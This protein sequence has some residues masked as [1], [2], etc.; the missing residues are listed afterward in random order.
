M[1]RRV[2]VR[3]DIHVPCE[4]CRELLVGDLPDEIGH[5]EREH[6][7]VLISKDTKTISV[8][9]KEPIHRTIAILGHPAPK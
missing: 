5:Y 9:G 4:E 2:R 3:S 7:Y 1:D 6:G 8:P